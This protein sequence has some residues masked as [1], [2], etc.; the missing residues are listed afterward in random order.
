ML[1]GILVSF[2][3]LEIILTPISYY[4]AILLEQVIYE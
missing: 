4:G 1:L 3:V 2:V